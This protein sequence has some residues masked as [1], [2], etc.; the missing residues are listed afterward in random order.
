MHCSAEPLNFQ[1]ELSCSAKMQ[2]GPAVWKE[3]CRLS[4]PELK[5]VLS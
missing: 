2:N 3:L 1:A 5:R 4:S